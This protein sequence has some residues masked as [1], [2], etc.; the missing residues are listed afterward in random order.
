MDY[1]LGGQIRQAV[2]EHLRKGTKF[3]KD[4]KRDE[5]AEHLEKA[6]K[7]LFKWAAETVSK[8]LENRRR[9]EGMKYLYMACKIRGGEKADINNTSGKSEKSKEKLEQSP[10]IEGIVQQ[11]IHI[12]NLTWD[13]IG[14]LEETKN[15]IKY[16]LASAIAKPPVDVKISLWRNI[17]FYGPPGTGK[18]LLAAA[19]SNALKTSKGK[20]L[21]FNVKVSSVLS[22]YFGESTKIISALFDTARDHTPAVVFLDEFESLTPKR[23]E[24]ASGPERRILST[25]LAE[26]D[27]LAEKGRTDV[28]VL[29]IAATNRPWDIDSAVLSRFE[30]KILIPLPDKDTRRRIFDILL[31]KQGFKFDFDI[32]KLVDA[33]KGFSGREIERLCKEATGHMLSEMNEQLPELFDSGIDEVKKYQMKIRILEFSD[34]DKHLQAMTPAT[35][36]DDVEKYKQWKEETDI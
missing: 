34:F 10:E 30:K 23:S 5:A 19:T 4:D 17:L 1:N 29:T 33:T 27:G 7:L 28:F 20:A 24:D 25:L 9:D 26:L 31:S 13:D 14:G 16:T 2:D 32:K 11:L 21:F 36:A 3:Y 35:S 12:S 15:D 22:K 18:T 6:S 8:T